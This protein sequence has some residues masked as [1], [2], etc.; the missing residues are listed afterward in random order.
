VRLRFWL[1]MLDLAEWLRV[2]QSVYLW[3]VGRA[4]A[5]VYYE[6]LDLSSESAQGFE[7]PW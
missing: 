1:A 7:A 6:Q 5:A 2:P 3:V 4:G